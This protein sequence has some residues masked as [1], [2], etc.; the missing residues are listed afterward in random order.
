[1]KPHVE[2]V[3]GYKYTL[4]CLYLVDMQARGTPDDQVAGLDTFLRT[5]RKEVHVEVKHG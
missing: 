1:M 4:W 3:I 2:L 5:W